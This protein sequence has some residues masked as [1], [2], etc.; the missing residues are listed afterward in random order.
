MNLYLHRAG[1]SNDVIGYANAMPAMVIGLPVASAS[2]RYGRRP[3]LI[4]GTIVA[5][6]GTVALA[7]STTTLPLL[8]SALLMGI[9]TSC[10]FSVEAASWRL[11]A[12]SSRCA[13]VSS[14]PSAS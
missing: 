7:F 2:D 12:A 13:A 11:S 3:F 4:F 8:A 14:S 6:I 10:I 9:G 5:A 1:I